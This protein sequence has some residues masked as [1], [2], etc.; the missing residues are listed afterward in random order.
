MTLLLFALCCLG[1]VGLPYVPA[2]AEWL[3]GT[4]A[5]ALPIA[6]AYHETHVALPQQVRHDLL[7]PDGARHATS[8]RLETDAGASVSVVAA[9]DDL[10]LGAGTTVAEHAHAGAHLRV[11][12]GCTLRGSA[13]SDGA[14]AVSAGT[15]FERLHAPALFLGGPHAP[16]PRWVAQRQ[17]APAARRDASGRY[18]VSGDLDVP[19]GAVVGGTLIAS[20]TVRLGAGAHVDGDVRAGGDLVLGDQATVVGHAFSDHSLTLESHATVEGAAIAR[21]RLALGAH[22]RVGRH[23]RPATA[24]ADIVEASAGALVHGTLWARVRGHVG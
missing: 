7:T 16:K 19:E 22:A 21:R 18:V 10:V 4:D 17:F 3:R 24:T 11:G 1:L 5:L 15:R 12:P 20:G 13:S 23:D 8:A 2:L 6:E 14:A 9:G